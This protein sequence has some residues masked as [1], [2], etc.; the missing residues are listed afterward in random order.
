[1]CVSLWA[2]G[3]PLTD[4]PLS[5]GPSSLS[6]PFVMTVGP[7]LYQ[8]NHSTQLFIYVPNPW[9]PSHDPYTP[10]PSLLPLIQL[11]TLN[12]RTKSSL[13]QISGL[14]ISHSQYSDSSRGSVYCQYMPPDAIHPPTYRASLDRFLPSSTNDVFQHRSGRCCSSDLWK[15]HRKRRRDE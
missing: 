2:S 8:L 5:A 11:T 14:V 7:L 12:S 9:H 13:S 4:S 10:D 15:E 6:G 1:M 3:G